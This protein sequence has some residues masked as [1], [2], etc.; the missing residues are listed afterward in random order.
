MTKIKT[1]F[2]KNIISTIIKIIGFVKDFFNRKVL[3]KPKNTIIFTV[4]FVFIIL[5]GVQ[6]YI[7][8]NNNS[9]YNNH[10]DDI[11]QYYVILEGFIRSIKEG[12]LSFFDLNNY[13][14]ASLFSNLYYVPLDLLTL[15]TL[16]LSF[17]MPT[18][19][20][21]STMELMKIVIGVGLLGIYLAL[22][23]YKNSTIF[24]ISIL[25]FINGGTVSF[26]NFPAFLSMTVYLPL[27]LIVIHYFFE[28]KYWVVPL[29]VLMIVFY[30]FYLAYMLLAFISFAYLIEYFKY[31]SFKISDFLIKGV[32]FLSL[33][34]L[35]VLMS[36]VVLLPA[37]T[38]I[39]EE[40]IRTSVTFKPWIV[41]LKIFE[42]KLYDPQVYIR[43]FAK[44]YSPQRPV[45]FRGFLNDYKLEHVSNYIS[46]IGF[47]LMTLVIFMRGKI[48]NVYKIMFAFVIVF[49]LLPIFSSILSGT[50]IMELFSSSDQEAFPYN[51]WLN[52]FP[53]LQVL[54][55]AHVYENFEFKTKKRFLSLITWSLISAIGIYLIIYYHKQ[56]DG[57]HGLKDFVIETLTY[58]RIFM[59][60]SL[61]ILAAGILLIVFKRHQWIKV[62][63]LGELVI[64]VGYIFVSGFASMNRI[65]QFKEMNEI[66][67]FMNENID[68]EQFTRV[69]VNMD[70]FNIVDH[71]YNQMTSFPTNS[72]I[73]HSWSDSETDNLVFLIFPTL[74]ENSERQSKIKMN[75]YSYYL[76]TFLGYKYVLTEALNQSF[77]DSEDFEF[78]A[79]NS[80]FALYKINTVESF[81][82]Y[83]KY[84]TYSTFKDFSRN[85]SQISA[86]KLFLSAVMID[87]ERYQ[88]DYDFE[89]FLLEEMM[90]EDLQDFEIEGNIR[91]YDTLRVSETVQR[92]K[93]DSEEMAEFYVYDDF[94]IDYPSGE[95]VLKD[96]NHPISDYG[97]AFYLDSSGRE[98]ACSLRIM[99]DN[100]QKTTI[101]CGQFFSP[102]EKVFIEKTDEISSAPS[103]ITR[104]ER[105]VDGAAYLV[106]DLNNLSRDLSG[107][108]LSFDFNG[109]DLGKTFIETTE[110]ERIYSVNG[111]FFYSENMSKVYVYKT[112]QLY[113]HSDLS[114][115]F[116]K[117]SAFDLI[118]NS[119]VQVENKSLI[120]KNGKIDLSYQYNGPSTKNNIVTIPVTYSDDWEFTSEQK[121]DKISVSGGFLGII[122]PEGTQAVDIS[123][124]F[125]PKNIGNGLKLSMIGSAI[126]LGLISYPLIK[127]KLKRSDE[128]D[129]SQI[130]HTSI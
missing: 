124:K 43:Y 74:G 85:Y 58:D 3:N 17:V 83:D 71:N 93:L 75:Y 64:A 46:I 73:F 59:I 122:I 110:G 37:I 107:K 117:Y 65:A 34:L 87:E 57:E 101:H 32:S 60:V 118:E 4:L 12:S 116:L 40:T 66:N 7:I 103:Y 48:A 86:E 19:V 31:R 26:M 111:L 109:Y 113:G 14:G 39:S 30:N 1:F 63:I 11:L 68:D 6:L 25:Y 47:L 70:D 44:M 82:V 55:V 33:L 62:L 89:N 52:M 15:L 67:D 114:V 21:I 84:L 49:S 105:A 76:S 18:V 112:A 127:R 128:N 94:I 129:E 45:S 92:K 90:S 78:I 53:I 98:I 91:A 28:K 80:Q 20:A 35:G 2:Q 9:V 99:K 42:L 51:R 16:L 102:I 13:F 120:I 50:F 123:L 38:F 104:K 24:W 121:Y 130:D 56:M 125:V 96:N 41:D 95:F 97:Q 5:I 27:A 79:S 69:Y 126:Y 36:S 29:Y 8:L 72:R 119:S 22:K 77:S 108:V 23:K 115:L 100:D 54:V 106:Y 10:S 81:Y 61:S 88:D